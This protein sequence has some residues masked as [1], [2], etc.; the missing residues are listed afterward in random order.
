MCRR[1][2]GKG[3]IECFDRHRIPFWRPEGME[4]MP[5][6]VRLPDPHRAPADVLARAYGIAEAM[7]ASEP[8]GN[9]SES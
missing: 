6:L 9:S 5:A 7:Y 3:L 4:R 1:H 8:S 2:G